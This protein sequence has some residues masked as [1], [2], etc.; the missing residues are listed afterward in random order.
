MQHFI[1]TF[2][3]HGFHCTNA[4]SHGS[5]VAEDESPLV[6]VSRVMSATH[7]VLQHIEVGLHGLVAQCH[8]GTS[9]FSLT[10]ARAGAHDGNCQERYAEAA[11]NPKGEVVYFVI[12]WS[13]CK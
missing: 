7:R 2:L 9:Q 4:T 6:P 8:G 5:M 1:R 3:H 10:Y 13:I 11:K 12:D